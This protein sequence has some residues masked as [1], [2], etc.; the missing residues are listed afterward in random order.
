VKLSIHEPRG[1]RRA[2]DGERLVASTAFI[3]N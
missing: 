1:G 2:Y 3:M